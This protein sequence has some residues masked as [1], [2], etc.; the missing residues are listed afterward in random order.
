[1]ERRIAGSGFFASIRK[2]PTRPFNGSG[3]QV[4]HLYAGMDLR[5]YF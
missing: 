3:A 2:I 4:A 1:M 5:K